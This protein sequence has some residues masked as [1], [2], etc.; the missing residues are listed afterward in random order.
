[1]TFNIRYYRAPNDGLDAWEYRRKMVADILENS[2]ADAIGLQEAEFPQMEYLREKLNDDFGILVTYGY[3]TEMG[4]SN[5]LLYR[6]SRFAVGEWGTFWF[7]DTPDKP[8]SKG[9]GNGSPRFCTWTRLVE[10]ETGKSFYFYNAHL[11]HR[12]QY[13]REKSARLITDRI[14]Q[15]KHR[16]PFVIIGDLNSKED[17]N[18]IRFLKGG[19]LSLDGQACRTAVPVVD[20]F[21]V[22]HGDEVDA[23]T[24]NGFDKDRPFIKIDYILTEAAMK[25]LEAEVITY[26]E[27]G[28]YPSDHCPVTATI[29]FQ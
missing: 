28:R 12:S 25:V 23:G 4:H 26:N 18:V 15:R 20:T 27:D 9:W 8:G 16:A 1:M 29:R 17:N 19:E 11:D 6:K 13:S 22:K 14:N 2:G 10:I 7:S 21:R 3:G 24:L 5:A